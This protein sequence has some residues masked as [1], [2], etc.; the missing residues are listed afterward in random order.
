MTTFTTSGP[1]EARVRF[2]G[3]AVEVEATDAGPTTACVEA[4]DP[5]DDRSVEAARGARIDCVGNRLTVDVPGKGRWRGGIR[6]RIRLALPTES[7]LTSESADVRLHTSGALAAVRVRTGSGK[8]EVAEVKDL[9]VKAG[10][11]DVTISG[12]PRRISF[13]TGNGHLTAETVG[14]VL[15]KTG[16]GKVTLKRSTGAVYV[17]GGNVAL[18]LAAADTGE[19]LFQTGAGNAHVG[20]VK[21]TSVQLDLQSSLG[22]VRCDLPME[23]SAPAGGS[24]LKIKLVTGIGDL[25]V[26]RASSCGAA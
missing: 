7:S 25:V 3:G 5:H 15:F 1:V 19:V 26:A 14:D 24:D 21:G 12:T 8:V 18:E 6:V 2:H 22:D 16:H 9:D 20:V 11:A 4:L 23:D 10:D 13:T 17:K